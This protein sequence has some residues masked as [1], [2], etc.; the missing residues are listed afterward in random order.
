MKQKDVAKTLGIH[1][2]YLCRI[3]NNEKPLTVLLLSKLEEIYDTSVR[4]QHD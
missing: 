2:S 3:E 4:E 1:K